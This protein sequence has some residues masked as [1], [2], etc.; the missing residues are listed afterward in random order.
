MKKSNFDYH[1]NILSSAIALALVGVGSTHIALAQE[2]GAGDVEV[3]AVS[4]IR[5]SLLSSANIKRE[6]SGVVDA[7]TAEDI[8][9]F[10]DTN[11]AESLQRIT[12][13]SIDRSNNEGNQVSVR[14]FGPTFNMVT[15]NGRAMP[16]SST[17]S[18]DVGI[19]RAFNFQHIASE[20]VSGVQVFKTGKADMASGG[21]GATVNLSTAKP[22]QL[23]DQKITFGLKGIADTT[24]VTGSDITPEF[25]GLYSN[26]FADGKLGILV[27]YA[28]SQRDSRKEAVVNDGWIRDNGSVYT[29]IDSSNLT[30]PDNPGGFYWVPRNFAVEYGDHERERENFQAVAQFAPNEDITI[31]LDYTGSRF[32][33]E[34]DRIQTGF[35]FDSDANT[36]GSV[37]TNGTVIN[38]RHNNHRLNFTSIRQLVETENDSFG[39]NVDWTVSDTLTLEFDIHDSTS[40]TQPGGQISEFTTVISTPPDQRYVDIGLDFTDNDVPAVFAEVTNTFDENAPAPLPAN[41]DPYGLE[42]IDGDVVVIRGHEIENNIQEWAFSGDWVNDSD[43]ALSNIRFGV[44]STDYQFDIKRRFGFSVI[45]NVLDIPDLGLSFTPS[46][47]GSNFSGGDSLFPVQYNADA[48]R[49]NQAI[50]DGNLVGENPVSLDTVQEETLHAYL[51]MDFETEFNEIPININVGIRYED[52]DVTASS[53]TT[54]PTNLLYI[55]DE[56][57]RTV[58]QG[59]TGA[60]TDTLEGGYTEFLPNFDVNLELKEDLFA[61]FSYSRTLTRSDVTAI[62][63]STSITN[64]RPGGPFNATQG[65]PNL[66]PYSSNNID[67]SLEWYYD[68]GSYISGGYFKKYVSNFIGITNESRTI[69][70]AD[71]TPLKDPSF[72][73]RPQCPDSNQNPP[74]PACLGMASDP[75]VIF[76]VE[77]PKNL[78]DATVDGVEIALQH[79]FGESGFGTQVNYTA[80]NGSVEYDVNSFDQTVALTGLSDSANLVGFYDKD[81]IQVRVAYN[82]RDD[83]LLNTNQFHSPNEPQFT[84]AYGQLDLSISY[85]INEYLVITFEGLNVTEET[86]RRHGRFSNQFLAAEDF[87]S[88]YALGVRAT[89]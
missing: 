81:G 83:F 74:N 11:L 28:N 60:V 56:E 51:A 72:N 52:T 30:N 75:D 33:E 48:G 80:V 49:V 47:I 32:E 88:R 26:V 64:L 85:D 27:A 67:L 65:D 29:G 1:R 24:N 17:L 12:G 59:S 13:V 40:Q 41:Y 89:F 23:G 3:I 34:I 39:L 55:S 79:M 4:G 62:A 7:I 14:G 84:E 78:E 10:P 70:G 50:V 46:T 31:S 76:N 44:G 43:S 21:I 9:K 53:N 73:P 18:T 87:G 8:G 86:T 54:L 57:I 38:P 20:V 15:L 42:S 5:G 25:S 71:G 45:Y 68:E 19:N 35:W 22:L 58:F 77:V 16:T 6:S 82:W 2:A 36:V 66:L 37:D 69:N 61:R 63:P